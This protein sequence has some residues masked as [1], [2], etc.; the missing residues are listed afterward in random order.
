VAAQNQ[1][2][3]NLTANAKGFVAGTSQAQ[4]ALQNFNQGILASTQ[5]VTRFRGA[6]GQFI[7][8][9]QA[10]KQVVAQL[11]AEK[12]KMLAIENQLSQVLSKSE[13]ALLRSSG[14][15]KG[16]SAGTGSASF[17]LLSLGQAF[18]D[19]AQFGMGFAQGFRAINNN[20]QQTFTA[21][22]LGSVQMGGFNNLIKAMGGS[23]L[24]PGGLILAFSALS[25]GV[26]FFATRAQKAAKDADELAKSFNEA[27]DSVFTFQDSLSGMSVKI[28]ESAIT[29]L[30]IELEKQIDAIDNLIAKSEES[31]QEL[32]RIASIA[33]SEE[34][35]QKAVNA[36][37][38]IVAAK[39]EVATL[40]M[41]RIEGQRRL[42]ALLK[43]Q[44]GFLEKRNELLEIAKSLGLDL[45][46]DERKS[47]ERKLK[48]NQY[49]TE[50][51]KLLMKVADLNEL[52]G[53]DEEV[54][55]G[56][57]EAQIGLLGQIN[58]LNQEK[59][60]LE[61]IS[62]QLAAVQAGA[63][64]TLIASQIQRIVN[65]RDETEALREKI[66][67]QLLDLGMTNDQI[68]QLKMFGKT[69]EE[70]MTRA[71]KATARLNEAFAKA[72]AQGLAQ[73]ATGFI[74]MAVNGTSFKQA[75]LSPLADMAIQLGKTAISIGITMLQ[76]RS[77]F[78]KPGPAIAAGVA[79]LALGKVI[80]SSIG[81]SSSGRRS[82]VSSAASGRFTAPSFGAMSMVPT[83]G[84]G[85]VF[86]S[87]MFS[88]V[89]QGGQ[90]VQLVASG[91][92]LV[93]V[94]GSEMS[95]SSRRVGGTPVSFS[96]VTAAS[97]VFVDINRDDLVK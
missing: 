83:I 86:Q 64:Q 94:V 31:S 21:I 81:K 59:A 48:G 30:R 4:K 87:Q 80:K 97:G 44:E 69:A 63:D 72:A 78:S 34:I 50:S 14:A 66:R 3:V 10:A 26:E 90:N 54:R 96:G 35:L 93:S 55:V 37:N 60:G 47:N 11:T 89:P 1:V 91:R 33:R 19:S 36:E 16:L 70:E 67:E 12:Q 68:D 7:T 13:M 92:S 9:A 49:L 5:G 2:I 46:E 28:P 25:A 15:V 39:E 61:A 43:Q 23:L 42:L 8:T 40:D 6:N 32:F 24:G 62:A 71:E 65:T 27:A 76:L 75:I 57:L 17:A 79:L 73:M 20:I 52:I 82:A 22:A 84:Q 88:P 53:S 77:V 18:Q 29:P 38:E 58:E 56:Q 41:D 51:E 95:A 85:S 45:T 74:D